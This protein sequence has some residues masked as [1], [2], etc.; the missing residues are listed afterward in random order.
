MTIACFDCLAGA[1][2]NMILGALFDAG[3]DRQAW[4]DGMDRLGLPGWSIR[5]E[6]VRRGGIGAMHVTVE[7][8]QEPLP[9]RPLADILSLLEGSGLTANV[10]EQAA[11]IFT[12]LAE[13]EARVH[14]TSPQEVHFH[15][16]GAAD[17]IVDI[18]GSVLG[19]ELLGV[20]R[21]LVSALPI[22]RG[23]GESQH[24]TLPLPAPATLELLMGWPVE[25]HGL[26]GERVT[27]TG[28]AILTTLG[29]HFRTF[30]P[31]TVETV[32]HGA[33][34][35]EEM[36]PNLLRLLI[37]EPLFP[38]GPQERITVLATNIDDMNPQVY[39]TVTA[40]LLD[41]GA[42]DV[43]LT[44]TIMK[45]GRPGTQVTVLSPADRET[46]CVDLLLTH[47]TTLGVRRQVVE[48]YTLERHM[49]E[50]STPFGTIR[51]KAACRDGR[52]LRVMPEYEDCLKVAQEQG[53]PVTDVQ[54]AAV[55]AGDQ[56]R[57]ERLPS[58]GNLH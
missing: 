35:R 33:G 10:R 28:A 31:M 11:R 24:G 6:T 56:F 8:A 41:S 37:G 29:Q 2:G 53:I 49:I 18:V 7:T 23:W 12:R 57:G 16:V 52:I 32:G 4:Q 42:L 3:V 17:A 34:S 44:P 27:P 22:H 13:A 48:R 46:A 5:L 20:S 21:V 55:A 9:E 45:S 50:L 30:P 1:S 39:P 19:L 43:F 47:T 58:T 25:D 14:R 51:G 40:E 26:E 54:R 15:E 36:R 38:D